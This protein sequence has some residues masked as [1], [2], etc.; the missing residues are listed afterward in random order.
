M[1]CYKLKISKAFAPSILNFV[2]AVKERMYM[3]DKREIKALINKETGGVI[4]IP[5]AERPTI[6]AYKSFKRPLY[7]M[8]VRAAVIGN[9]EKML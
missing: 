8:T 2:K 6:R 9:K 1:F 4:P 7:Q 3:N 5:E